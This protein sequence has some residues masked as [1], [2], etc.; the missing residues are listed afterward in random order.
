VGVVTGKM[1]GKS[2]RAMVRGWVICGPK[3][4]GLPI[5][6]H[7]E[8]QLLKFHFDVMATVSGYMK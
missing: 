3:N 8:N 4:A 5:L 2:A 1:Q 6:K 7:Y